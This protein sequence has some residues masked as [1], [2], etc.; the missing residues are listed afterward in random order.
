MKTP[1]ETSPADAAATEHDLLELSE[2]RSSA[3]APAAPEARGEIADLQVWD[4]PIDERGHQVGAVG[5]S[6]VSIGEDLVQQGVDD[7]DADVR[8]QVEE[9]PD[10]T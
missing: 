4:E 8:K 3:Q 5:E 7:A 1:D 9:S 6:D 10:A 2:L